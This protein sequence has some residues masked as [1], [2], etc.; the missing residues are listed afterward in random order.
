MQEF[1]ILSGVNKMLM[2]DITKSDKLYGKYSQ[3]EMLDKETLEMLKKCAEGNYD[4]IR[5]VFDS[6]VPEAEELI[7]TIKQ[8]KEIRDKEAIRVSVHALAGICG[9]IGAERLRKI[10]SDMEGLVKS[11]KG[12][13]AFELIEV[14]LLTWTELSDDIT[15]FQHSLKK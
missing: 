11:G 13:K 6:F 9:S 1:P 15:R 14:L 12:S 8:Q 7:R 3:V 2:T 5:D 10:A 4:I